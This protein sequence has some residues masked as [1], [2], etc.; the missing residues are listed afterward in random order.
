MITRL[1]GELHP[2]HAFGGQLCGALLKAS[3]PTGMRLAFRKDECERVKKFGARIM[4]LDQLEGVKVSD[5][6][7]LCSLLR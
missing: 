5:Q 4:T 6:T 3:M 2:M 7:V 1:S